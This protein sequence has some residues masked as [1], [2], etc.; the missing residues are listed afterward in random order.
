MASASA[1]APPPVKPQA[2]VHALEQVQQAIDRLK[3]TIKPDLANSLDFQ[4]DQGSGRTVVR[5]MDAETNSLIRQI[6]SE[7]MVAIADA[8]D[9]MQGRSGLVKQQV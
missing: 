1:S 9:N 4:I 3:Q 2:A 5:I 6:P 7:E 8:I